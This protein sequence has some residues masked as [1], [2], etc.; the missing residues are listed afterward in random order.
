MHGSERL[1]LHQAG[2]R[3]P[4]LEHRKRGKRLCTRQE[5]QPGNEDAGQRRPARARQHVLHQPRPVKAQAFP[6]DSRRPAHLRLLVHQSECNRSK[7]PLHPRRVLSLARHGNPPCLRNQLRH[8]LQHP[9]RNAS[10][11]N[12][13]PPFRQV[14]EHL[15]RQRFKRKI[16]ARRRHR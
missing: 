7:R 11:Q 4:G 10:P 6:A 1:Q 15:Q 9:H 8:R 14:R 13:N 16:K 2:S 12:G 5:H 3:T